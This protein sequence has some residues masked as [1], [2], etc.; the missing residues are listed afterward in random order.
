MFG[1]LMPKGHRCRFTDY[2]DTPA[3]TL[4]T[5]TTTIGYLFNFL[6]NMCAACWFYQLAALW[7]FLHTSG[8]GYFSAPLQPYVGEAN[9]GFVS[10]LRIL[11]L[12]H[13]S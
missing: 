3:Y 4:T 11:G 1:V 12:L 6:V 8:P 13:I 10:L 2:F 7:C 5:R 9:K